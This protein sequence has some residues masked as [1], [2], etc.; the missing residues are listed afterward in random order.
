MTDLSEFEP[1]NNENY[2]EF[3]LP[4]LEI[5]ERSKYWYRMRVLSAYDEFIP[6]PFEWPDGGDIIKR[7]GATEGDSESSARR[8]GTGGDVSPH[9]GG[10]RGDEIPP[11]GIHR[12]KRFFQTEDILKRSEE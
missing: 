3:H 12:L 6:M 8:S 10:N 9:E 4:R 1:V 2:L 11:L 7:G 5:V